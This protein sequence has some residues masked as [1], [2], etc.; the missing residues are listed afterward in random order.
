MELQEREDTEVLAMEEEVTEEEV[1]KE[2][3]MNELENGIVVARN[4]SLKAFLNY[5]ETGLTVNVRLLD[6]KVIIHEVPLGS[7]GAV[8]GEIGRQMVIWHNDLRIFV[9]RDVIV[10][11]NS[12]L[13]PDGSI[14]P[15]QLPRPPV[16]QDCDSSGWAYPTVVVEVGLSEGLESLHSLAGRYFSVRTTIQVYIAIKIFGYR[17]NGTRTL[18]AFVYEH[19]S[20]NPRRPILIKSFGTASMHRRSVRFFIRKGIPNHNITGFGRFSAPPCNGSGIQI[21]QINI[22]A[23]AIFHGSNIAIPNNLVNGFNLDLYKLQRK[24]LLF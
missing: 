21:Y 20:P 4:I 3:T 6:G 15:Y 1:A 19:T 2:E 18:V 8:A 16:G 5:K 22:P 7:H 9:E 23:A 13:H 17:R 14:Q 11:M 10:N 24:A 12:V